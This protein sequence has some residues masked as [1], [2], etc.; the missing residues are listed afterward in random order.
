MKGFGIFS[1]ST[2]SYN[3]QS[4]AQD[5]RCQLLKSPETDLVLYL[6]NHP[7]MERLSKRY[8][9]NVSCPETWLAY[10]RLTWIIRPRIL[11]LRNEVQ[12]HFRFTLVS[13][14]MVS[15]LT[16]HTY[17]IQ[18]LILTMQALIIHIWSHSRHASEP[19][20][21]TL[22]HLWICCCQHTECHPSDTKLLGAGRAHR[23]PTQFNIW[24]YGWSVCEGRRITAITVILRVNLSFGVVSFGF[25]HWL[26]D[27]PRC[28]HGSHQR[29]HLLWWLARTPF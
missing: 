28:S 10:F 21:P 16:L 17:S 7:G 2:M 8:P 15:D 6:S 29:T 27:S 24:I 19:C 1:E 23:A 13:S 5:N 12:A 25:P 4:I 9:V 14:V 26:G 3:S 20:I 11:S 18:R 22:H